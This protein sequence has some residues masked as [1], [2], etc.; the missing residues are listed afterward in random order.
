MIAYLLRHLVA[1]V[2]ALVFAVAGVHWLGPAQ[3][4]ELASW[5]P[6]EWAGVVA[7][8]TGV[9]TV[10]GA[11]VWCIGWDAWRRRRP[12]RSVVRLIG[13]W[14]AGGMV[15]G[16]GAAMVVRAAIGL[17]GVSQWPTGVTALI[18]VALTVALIAVW[19]VMC[20]L[21]QWCIPERGANDGADNG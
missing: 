6:W 13:L 17:W 11:M 21:S 18:E 8:L 16:L 1:C 20:W 19:S 3:D 5:T 12:R 15:A 9:V 7:Q 4:A 2:V 10:L 14:L